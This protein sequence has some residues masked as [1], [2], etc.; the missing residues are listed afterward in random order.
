MARQPT[1]AAMFRDLLRA[2]QDLG[3]QQTQAPPQNAQTNSNT[4]SSVVEQFRRYKPPTFNGIAGPLAAEEWIRGLERI[5]KHLSC[6]DAQKVLCVEFMLVDAAGH[7]WE[8]VSRTRTEAQQRN[9]T[10][11]RFKEEVMGKYFPQALRDRKEIEFLQL[12]QGKMALLDYERKFEQL[13]RYT[14]HLV[15]TEQKKARRFELRLRPEIGGIMA[16][17]EFTT[18]SQVLQRAQ[19]IANRLGLDQTTQESTEFS[20]KRK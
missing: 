4:T 16:S 20:G 13:S 2:V 1:Q 18:Y 11:A 7:W 6:T 5:F 8:S 17:H 12:K 15:D 19:A 14:T 3:K 10:W 9:L